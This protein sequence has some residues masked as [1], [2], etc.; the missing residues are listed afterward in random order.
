MDAI[1]DAE[2]QMILSSQIDGAQMFLR[3]KRVPNSSCQPQ[4]WAA[5]ICCCLP[6]GQENKSICG[7]NNRLIPVVAYENG[8]DSAI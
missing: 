1:G 4:V 7:V 5:R 8:Y 2:V 6:R 3:Q